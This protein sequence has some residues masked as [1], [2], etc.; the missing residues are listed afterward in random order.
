[1]A[2]LSSFNP[3]ATA[4]ID[5]RFEKSIRYFTA[6]CWQ[7]FNNSFNKYGLNDLS[8]EAKTVKMGLLYLVKYGIPA[9]GKAYIDDKKH[10]DK[11]KL[12]PKSIGIAR[13]QS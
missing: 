1:M 6:V 3:K 4:V 12:C 13:W 9:A 2:A 7:Q 5:K 8:Y 10:P 11:G